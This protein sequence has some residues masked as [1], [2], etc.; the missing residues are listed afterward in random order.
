MRKILKPVYILSWVFYNSY[1]KDGR[2]SAFFMA[3]GVPTLLLVSNI[4]ALYIL[5]FIDN[6]SEIKSSFWEENSDLSIW[7]WQALLWSAPIF[8]VPFTFFYLGMFWRYDWEKLFRS[9]D[10]KFHGKWNYLIG[11]V[12]YVV[13]S[14]LL[15]FLAIKSR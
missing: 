8:F 14:I 13:L 4:C 12:L 11:V 3:L 10:R 5:F 1:S 6:L 15:F 7:S 2:L 9:F